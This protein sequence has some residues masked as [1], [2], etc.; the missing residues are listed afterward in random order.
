[1]LDNVVFR[2]EAA[3]WRDYAGKVEWLDTIDGGEGYR[4]KKLRYEALPGLW[5]PR[6][7]YEPTKL[8]GKVPVVLNVNGH[9][10]NGKAADYKQIR[11]INLAKRGMHRPERRMVRHGPASHARLRALPA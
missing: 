7:L 10:G 1:M 4:I 6:L 9:D 5:V 11:C 3:T 8:A 2:G